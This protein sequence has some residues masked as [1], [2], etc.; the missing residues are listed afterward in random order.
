M[1]ALGRALRRVSLHRHARET[2]ASYL[3]PALRP[4]ADLLERRGSLALEVSPTA[5]SYKG[6][7]VYSE[8][9]REGSLCFRLHRDGVRSITFLSGLD[10][11]ELVSF[12]A[13]ALPD[14]AGG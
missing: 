1:S 6:E 9:A 13:A 11:E 7:P 3:L 10:L 4:L 14:G 2:H 8:P 5:L 12:A